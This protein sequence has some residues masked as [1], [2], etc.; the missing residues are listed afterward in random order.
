MTVPTPWPA[1]APLTTPRL[2]LEPLRRAHAR[3]AVGVF[4]DVRL[5][6]WTGGAPSSLARLE[7]RYARQEAGRSPD[8]GQGWLNWILRR[9]ADGQV[10]GTVQATLNRP[11]TGGL[12]A[13]LAWVVGVPYQ[14]SGYAR[15][16]ALAMASW[17]LT[18]DV[19]ELVAY[20]HPRHDASMA[21]ARALG[22]TASDEVVDGEIRWNTT[23]GP[24]ATP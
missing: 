23:G 2:R 15:E 7:A 8:G 18:Q 1:A 20:I 3:E 14:G 11:A 17:L 9:R 6:T 4:D 16:G 13:S 19:T 24:R 21:V 22:L 12:E 5:H 10:V